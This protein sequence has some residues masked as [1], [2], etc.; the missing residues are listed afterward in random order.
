V[1][2]KSLVYKTT[3]YSP[4]MLTSFPSAKRPE[5]YRYIYLY[6]GGKVSALIPIHVMEEEP[7]REGRRYGKLHV[8][9]SGGEMR[10]SSPAL[11]LV[12]ASLIPNNSHVK[13]THSK[14]KVK[15]SP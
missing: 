13:L 10:K 7:Y 3:L 1:F 9:N 11:S 15:L 6:V 4:T 12:F 14:S 5:V 8:R 2:N